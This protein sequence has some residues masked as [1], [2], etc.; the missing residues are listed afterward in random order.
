MPEY[1]LTVNGPARTVDVSQ[2]MPPVW[3]LLDVVQLTG[4][5]SARAQ[6]EP[7]VAAWVT[8]DVPQCGYCQPGQLK[9]LVALFVRTPRPTGTEINSG[10]N[11]NLYR[12]GTY[13]RVRKVIHRAAERGRQ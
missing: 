8:E 3:G 7:L 13:S 11:A 4:T 10:T 5:K 12:C 9:S 1:S 6:T 2:D